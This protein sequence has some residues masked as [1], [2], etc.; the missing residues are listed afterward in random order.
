M[1]DRDFSIDFMTKSDQIKNIKNFML[2]LDFY[3]KEKIIKKLYRGFSKEFA[4]PIYNLDLKHLNFIDFAKYLFYFGDKSK[5]LWE[6]K[7]GRNFGIN[8]VSDRVFEYIFDLFKDIL[9]KN[10]TKNKKYIQ[11]NA[12]QF[13]FFQNK[14]NKKGFIIEI[15][16]LSE[17]KKN[18]LRNF[19][20]RI[21][22]Q[23]GE[24]QIVNE[25]I[26]IS[27]TEKEGETKRFSGKNGIKIYFWDFEFNNIP[28]TQNINIPIFQGNPYIKQ[29]EISIFG[30]IFP[31]YIY[32]VED[33]ENK[34]IIFNPAIEYIKN[35]DEII[36]SGFDIDQTNFTLNLKNQTSFEF[37]L[38]YNYSDFKLIN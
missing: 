28:F 26:L 24:T 11:N 3:K 2:R 9:E 15:N 19:Y 1:Y 21:I 29:Q 31:H 30:V 16:T 10:K 35:F 25:S 17:N 20:F 34:K 13:N 38:Q 36:L 27:T 6:Q 33:K 37:G 23:L 5:Y 8:D 22:H 14:E 4:F 12:A 7:N 18:E 32:A